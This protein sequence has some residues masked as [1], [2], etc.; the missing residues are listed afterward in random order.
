MAVEHYRENSA[1]LMVELEPI[2]QNLNY[3][4]NLQQYTH[5]AREHVVL[6]VCNTYCHYRVD[7]TYTGAVVLATAAT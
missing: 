7:A 2:D 6:P 3:D 1:G 5:L 4:F